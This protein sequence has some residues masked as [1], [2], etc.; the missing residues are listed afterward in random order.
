MPVNDVVAQ[1]R[2]VA[3]GV[4]DDETD[5]RTMARRALSIGWLAKGLLYV[6]VGLISLELARQGRIRTDADQTGALTALVE[7]ALG[8]VVVFA[9]SI[10]LVAYAIWQ[11]WSAI[12]A[13]NDGPI[14]VAKRIGWLGLAAVHLLLAHTGLLIAWEGGAPPS[15]SSERGPTT[16]TG[17]TRELLDWPAGRAIVIAIGIGTAAVGAY[18]AWNAVTG[19][20]LD[21]IETESLTPAEE[22]ALRALGTAGVAAR[23]ALLVMAGWL[24]VD[25]A[26]QR[27]A[28]R[29][30]GIDDALGELS[31]APLGTAI[32]VATGI[33][34]IAAGAY[35]ALTFRR[36]RVRQS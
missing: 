30:A 10:A 4:V 26:L 3:R 22:R 14:H 17:L 25:A 20:F 16:P 31:R 12:A 11:A 13:S 9:V 24:F 6:I 36:Q 34:L 7:V 28:R 1:L 32:L 18:N 27:N 29:A 21:D 15:T 8:R 23:A 33:G 5:S 19:E 2:S 35:D